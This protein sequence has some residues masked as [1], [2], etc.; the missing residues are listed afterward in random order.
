MFAV[1]CARLTSLPTDKGTLNKSLAFQQFAH[2]TNYGCEYV[3]VATNGTSAVCRTR[4]GGGRG[5]PAAGAEL[6]NSTYMGFAL[7]SHRW[8]C[9]QTLLPVSP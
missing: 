7:R 6:L 9:V 3:S 4:P 5:H 2:T 1:P 8:R